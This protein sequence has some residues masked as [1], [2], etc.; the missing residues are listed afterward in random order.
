LYGSQY[1]HEWFLSLDVSEGINQLTIH[2]PNYTFDSVVIHAMNDGQIKAYLKTSMQ[3]WQLTETPLV[4]HALEKM[5]FF[6]QRE[7]SSLLTLLRS[8]MF[9]MMFITLL[10]SMFMP[11]LLKALDP[12]A[13]R[14]LRQQQQHIQ[15]TVSHMLQPSSSST[16]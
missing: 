6:A 14:E 7:G 11:R 1:I 8:P 10:M 5:N 9:L 13:R 2:H 16:S 3:Q 15:E 12:E 4:I